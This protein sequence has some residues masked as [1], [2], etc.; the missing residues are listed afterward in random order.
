MV[1]EMNFDTDDVRIHQLAMNAFPDISLF[2]NS[3]G[4]G[5]EDLGLSH[6]AISTGSVFVNVTNID[7]FLRVEHL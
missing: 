1:H 2:Q 3:T 6:G 5:Q 7:S 4:A